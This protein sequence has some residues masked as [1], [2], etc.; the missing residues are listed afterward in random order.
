MKRT[1]IESWLAVHPESIHAPARGL[2]DRCESEIREH[3]EELAWTHARQVAEQ[4]LHRFE[5]GFGLP[6][7]EVFVTREVCHEIARELRRHEPHV[8]RR[9]ESEWVSLAV[10]E[11]LDPSARRMLRDWLFDVAEQE[12]HR[13]WLEIVAFTHKVARALIREARMTRTLDWD[14]DR[15]YPRLAARVTEMLIHEFEAHARDAGHR[16]PGGA[17]AP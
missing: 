2:L 10:L 11:A 15:S 6:A 1:E 16:A 7:S 5:R 3:A 14:F 9:M 4:S 8:D 13:T 12:E 17:G